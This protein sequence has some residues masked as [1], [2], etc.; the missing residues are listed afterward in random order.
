MTTIKRYPNR[1]LYDTEA[2]QYITLDGIAE[3]IKHGKEIRV[4]DNVS[5]EDLTALT[6]TQIISE[7]EKKQGGFL[8]LNL[9]SGLVQSGGDRLQEIQR[10]LLKSVGFLHLFDDELNRRIARLVAAGRLE[11]E[12]GER[13]VEL[14]AN[15]TQVEEPTAAAHP[16]ESQI[17]AL[18]AA[19][20]LP[21][22][23]DI[24]QL[25]E[26]LEELAAKL[27]TIKP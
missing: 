17:E 9:L 23:R 10:T 21:S 1:K 12:E 24:R 20:G 14:L 16:L 22:Q 19:R 2:K 26:Q 6:L 18:I 11:V 3:L 5:G 25:S 15:P 13:L 7:Q 8:P 27:E 4:V